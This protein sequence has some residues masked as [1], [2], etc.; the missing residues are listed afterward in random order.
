MGEREEIAEMAP[1]VRAKAGP[2]LPLRWRV[3]FG[4]LRT[5]T[6]PERTGPWLPGG[7]ERLAHR[8]PRPIVVV[9]RQAEERGADRLE[10]RQGVRGRGGVIRRLF[11]V[12]WGRG[13]DGERHGL[14]IHV[15]VR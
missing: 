11:L 5:P 2:F 13:R 7:V 4:A 15:E 6:V 8:E 12:V 9:R 10:V 1:A 3:V 14:G